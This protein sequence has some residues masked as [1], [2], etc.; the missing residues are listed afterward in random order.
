LIV[1]VKLILT[2]DI[3]PDKEQEYFE[4]VIR[5]FIPGVQRLGFDLTDA[6]ATVY[7]Q[8]PQIQVDARVPTLAKAQ[9]ITRSAEWS[10]L[11]DQLMDF[12]QNYSMKI[13]QARGGFQF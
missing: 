12:V 9:Q 2:W 1:T 4:F 8:R 11:H 5:E 13:V 10:K 6:W 7:G 3:A